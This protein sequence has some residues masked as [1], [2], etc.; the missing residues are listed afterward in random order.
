MKYYNQNSYAAVPYPSS[1]NKTATV[2]SGGCGVCCASTVLSFFNVNYPPNQ[3]ASVFI[4]RGA[5]VDGGTD[6]TKAAKLVCEFAPGVSFSTT[7]SEVE[8]AQCLQAGGIAIANVG[9]NRT[10]YTGVFSDSGHYIV[11]CGMEGGKFVIFDVGNYSGK[12]NKAG[13]KE[14]V[15]V[16]GDFVYCSEKV[17]HE[18]T[19][20][21]TPNYYLF[22][23][24]ELL[25][26]Q[27][28]KCI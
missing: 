14:K 21:R 3:L 15:T 2:K 25:G 27:P 17:L 11:I 7:S 4:A 5:R 9:G 28:F 1:T 24:K 13:R 19:L 8:L 22:K 20:N 10:G 12:Y 23:G 26:K 16:K 6:M 18:D